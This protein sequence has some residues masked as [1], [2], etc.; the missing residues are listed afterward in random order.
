MIAKRIAIKNARKGNF[1]GLTKYLLDPQDKTERVGEVRITNCQSEDP[2]WAALEIQATQHMNTRARSDKSYH[3]VL[4]FRAGENPSRQVLEEIED[5]VSAGLGY[6]DHQRVSVIHRDTDN[7]HLHIAINKIHPRRFTILE[8]Y[9]DHRELARICTRLEAEYK[10]EVDNHVEKRS[11]RRSKASDMEQA[12]G[13]ESLTGWIE[14]HCLPQIDAAGSWEEL[15]KVL[16]EFDLQIKKRA[17]G[18]VIV[19]SKGLAVKASSISR[20]C[21]KHQ[22]ENRL[23]AFRPPKDPILKETPRQSYRK[24]AAAARIDTHRL[25]EEYQAEQEQNLDMR[26]AARATAGGEKSRLIASAK[27]SARLERA[28]VEF[29]PGGKVT[30]QVLR[31]IIR[32]RLRR[33]IA[34]INEEHREKQKR[35]SG[36]YRRSSWNDWLQERAAK[37]DAEA[38]QTLRSR[39]HQ[40][41]KGDAIAGENKAGGDFLN[42]PID[43]VTKNGTVIYRLPS[44]VSLRDDGNRLWVP[45]GAFGEVL[46]ETLRIAVEHYGPKLTVYGSDQFKEQIL[47]AAAVADFEVRFS[48][49]DLDKRRV[50]L[51]AVKSVED[52]AVKYVEER[53]AKRSRILDIA[54][55]RVFKPED[56]GGFLCAGLRRV[57]GQNLFLLKRDET[58]LVLPVDALVASRLKGLARGEP[59]TVTADGMVRRAAG[60]GMVR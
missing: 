44:G 12:G 11:A 14:R 1:V 37:R 53:N 58:V 34:K 7:L 30:K 48:N 32:R 54:E 36:R 3:L 26:S 25:W 21:S 33:R 6:A 42:L 4:S 5:K 29:G 43:S 59:L 17:N 40:S 35:V 46:L 23:G 19:D 41:E 39:S 10:L 51:G 60:K 57:D 22:L 20:Q 47:A 27:T 45:P 50:A 31:A 52:A 16:A 24:R 28:M 9:Y 49:R 56:A 55:H 18:L 13:V 15:H 2:G 8:P 38:L